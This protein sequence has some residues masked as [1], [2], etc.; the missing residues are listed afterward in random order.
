VNLL[1][2]VSKLLS[3][4]GAPAIPILSV[5]KK[6]DTAEL[7]I[8]RMAV[9]KRDR[10]VGEL[11]WEET[12]GYIFAMGN[13]HEGFLKIPM[14][15]GMAVMSI[16]EGKSEVTPTLSAEGKP[17]LGIK[18]D[19]LLDMKETNGFG[20]VQLKEIQDLLLG[21]AANIIR[22]QTLKCYQKT[23]QLNADIYGFSDQ[24]HRKYPGRWKELEQEWD[25]LY[26]GM[27][28]DISVKTTLVSTGKTSLT[29]D[30][31]ENRK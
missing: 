13:V 15:Q 10:M 4:T 22:E 7:E 6:G 21:E 28:M 27:P 9:F 18:L 24:F 16:V 8:S 12:V 19:V 26:P 30:M 29:L 23:Q 5:M 14:D 11:D 2:L 3:K 20:Q 31:E 25:T 1:K 17:S